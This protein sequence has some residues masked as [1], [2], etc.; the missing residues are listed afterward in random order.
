MRY[1]PQAA[2][3]EQHL[4]GYALSDQWPVWNKRGCRRR[5]FAEPDDAIEVGELAKLSSVRVSVSL[6]NMVNRS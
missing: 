5:R 1:L 6:T 2:K 3:R 4:R